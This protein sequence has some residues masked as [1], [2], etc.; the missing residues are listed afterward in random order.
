MADD[1][2]EWIT[3]AV[4]SSKLNALGFFAFT[5]LAAFPS[6]SFGVG[7]K[8]IAE[9]TGFLY[10]NT[11]TFAT[12]TWTKRTVDTVTI[13]TL[14]MWIGTEAGVDSAWKICDGT[15]I[16][17]TTYADLFALCGTE[18]GIGDGSTTF[19]LP[20]F[21]TSNLFPRGATDDTG[22]GGTGGESTH[23]LTIAELASHTHTYSNAYGGILTGNRAHVSGN[24]NVSATVSSGSTGSGTA[25]ENKPPYVD[26]HFIV[27]VL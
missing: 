4:T 21:Q 10:Q 26:V 3:E 13:G 15:A 19:N 25:H 7:S 17:R 12:P 20:D 5:N 1:D 8:G 23:V 6:S 9:D 11:G 22:R 24:D 14:T 16:S 27:K 18:Y 2:T